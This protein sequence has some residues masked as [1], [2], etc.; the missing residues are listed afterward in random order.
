MILSC[1]LVVFILC[2][3]PSHLSFKT[4]SDGVLVFTGRPE[5]DQ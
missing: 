5:A 3:M 2:N 4:T 1:V